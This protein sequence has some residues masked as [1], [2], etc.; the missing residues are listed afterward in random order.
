MFRKNN[1]LHLL[2]SCSGLM[3]ACLT[4][5]ISTAQTTSPAQPSKIDKPIWIINHAALETVNTVDVESYLNTLGF[6]QPDIT[7]YSNS[8]NPDTTSL[9]LRGLGANRTLILIDGRNAMT[10]NGS[11]YTDVDTIPIGLLKQITIQ[12]R[13]IAMRGSGAMSGAL[14]FE[15]DR[16]FSGTQVNASFE[17]DANGKS[18]Q[19]FLSVKSGHSFSG[20]KGRGVIYADYAKRDGVFNTDHI[21]SSR[22]LTDTG[23]ALTASGSIATPETQLSGPYDFSAVSGADPNNC[24]DGT[25][26]SGGACFGSATFDNDGNIIPFASVNRYNDF[27]DIYLKRPKE[28]FSLAGLA[29]FQ[30]SDGI[31]TSLT[32]VYT[33]NDVPSQ[34]SPTPFVTSIDINLN[35]NPF[36][37]QQTRAA[38][39]LTNGGNPLFSEFIGRRMSEIGPRRANSKSENFLL[40]ADLKGDLSNEWEWDVYFQYGLNNKKIETQGL[41]QAPKL[42]SLINDGSCNIFG[43]DTL[44][45]ACVASVRFDLDETS[46]SSSITLAGTVNGQVLNNIAP[47]S[48]TPLQLSSGI[49]FHKNDFD[50][51]PEFF[52]SFEITGLAPKDFIDAKQDQIDVFS[53]IHWPLISSQEGVDQ[54][55]I[56]A[57]LRHSILSGDGRVVEDYT[58]IILFGINTQGAPVFQDR[59]A[60]KTNVW[61]YAGHLNWTPSSALTVQAGFDRGFRLPNLR[62]QFAPRIRGGG[63]VSDPCYF[64]GGDAATCLASGIPQTLLGSGFQ[65]AGSFVQSI[66]G[67]N[68]QINPETS[69][70]WTIGFTWHP[71]INPSFSLSAHYQNLTIKDGI[72]E[73]GLDDI[74]IGCYAGITP[75]LCGRAPRNSGGNFIPVVDRSA[76]NAQTLKSETL[77][78]GMTYSREMPLFGLGG[79]FTVNAQGTYTFNQ[80]ADTFDTEDE[81][82][83]FDTRNYRSDRLI[84]DC[85]GHYAD[86]QFNN[87]CRNPLSKWKHTVNTRYDTGNYAVMAR[88]RYMSG[89]TGQTANASLGPTR[90]IPKIKNQHYL[91]LSGTWSISDRINLTG[92]VLNI[93]DNDPPVLGS[94]CSIT[95]NTYPGTYNPLGRK[96]FAAIK[97]DF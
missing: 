72:T 21:F 94:C 59:K 96:F 61:A 50:F 87:V 2:M 16:S 1:H 37:T 86:G 30:I 23:S 77:D 25:T 14:N 80:T 44:S 52:D 31:E 65:P 38:L 39:N 35:T 64:N 36:L 81:F 60:R 78:L 26:L 95:G 27:A 8:L 89:T 10:H 34:L 42:R 57:S 24:P 70:S 71:H 32:A 53:R 13:N 11:G 43:A 55:D 85:A 6:F 49:E 45:A 19:S 67:G 92:G 75:E 90:I 58:N 17:A 76:Q 56:T 69:K 46:K 93:F 3:V 41:L 20:G 83:N 73:L 63:F 9:K 68:P 5:A 12:T 62:E 40:R 7:A 48:K 22:R 33:Y 28:K 84:I 91:D 18:S 54:L 66:T 29:D 51:D 79:T 4:P 97:F 15:L 74:L 88:W 47:W 82:V